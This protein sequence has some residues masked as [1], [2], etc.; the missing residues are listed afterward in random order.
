MVLLLLTEPG[1][2]SAAV[3][4]AASLHVPAGRTSGLK[5]CLFSQFLMY[6]N[7]I[8]KAH[9]MQPR[10]T[11]AQ[12]QSPPHCVPLWPQLRNPQHSAKLTTQWRRLQPAEGRS[13]T[14][15]AQHAAGAHAVHQGTATRVCLPCDNNLMASVHAPGILQMTD[16]SA[17]SPASRRGMAQLLFALQATEVSEAAAGSG[18]Q[19]ASTEGAV[20]T[21]SDGDTMLAELHKVLHS[22]EAVPQPQV[23]ASSL[24]LV[25]PNLLTLSCWKCLL[26]WH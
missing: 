26:P 25:M 16:C 6:R 1:G 3:M 7:S 19:Q 18:L 22:Q 14:S 12:M 24:C 5:Q 21:A 11:L 2:S 10:T 20:L 13:A 23:T 8:W 15:M 4:P 9:T 17:P